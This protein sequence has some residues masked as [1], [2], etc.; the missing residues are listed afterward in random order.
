MAEAYTMLGMEN[1]HPE[2][3]G[4]LPVESRRP[5]IVE[6]NGSIRQFG[7]LAM[8]DDSIAGYVHQNHIIEAD[9]GTYATPT[10]RGPRR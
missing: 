2:R 7:M 9:R 3:V 8:L 4:L 10:R 1:N 6:G 5:F